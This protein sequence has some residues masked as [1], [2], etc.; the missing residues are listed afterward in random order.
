MMFR[1]LE[2]RE[3]KGRFVSYTACAALGLDSWVD[4]GWDGDE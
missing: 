1:S 3:V 2:R 4:A